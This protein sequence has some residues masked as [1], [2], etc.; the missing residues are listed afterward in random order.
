MKGLLFSLVS[1]FGLSVIL[2][3]VI[4]YFA[5]KFGAIDRPRP[6]HVHKR[7]VPTLGGIALYIAVTFPIALGVV[8]RYF[9]TGNLNPHLLGLLAGGFVI[10]LVGLT[11]DTL[12]LRWWLKLTLQ[13]AAAG[14]LIVFGYGVRFLAYE[15]Q[16]FGLELSNYVSV[17]LIIVWL[18]AATNASNL[19]DGLDGLCAGIIGIAAGTVAA[20]ALIRTDYIVA[21]LMF[22]LTGA[23]IG[24]LIFNFYPAKI[25]MGDTGALFLG[26]TYAGIAAI[27]NMKTMALTAF[28]V[29]M[30]ALA[31]PLMEVTY[32]VIRRSRKKRRISSRDTEFFHNKLARTRL[33]V[34]GAVLYVYLITAVL[35]I[36]TIVF[37]F[38]SRDFRLTILIILAV[39]FGLF[40]YLLENLK[41]ENITGT[42]N[43]R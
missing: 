22:A 3:P 43:G 2:T 35:G 1:S 24:F 16:F 5:R 40:V 12:E 14:L 4:I 8:R 26:F 17:L 25:I 21:E 19:V 9:L 34:R 37:N 18:V 23:C 11:D 36:T 41:I 30:I 7:P 28:I 27:V 38:V 33:G 13:I 31:I 20:L 42:K 29:P 39:F 10:F 6:G 32:A 15:F